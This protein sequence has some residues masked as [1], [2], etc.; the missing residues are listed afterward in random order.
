MRKITYTI[1]VLALFGSLRIYAQCDTCVIPLEEYINYALSYNPAI[2]KATNEL[3]LKT[4]AIKSAKS[5]LYPVISTDISGGF[6]NEYRSNLNYKTCMAVL[7]ADQAL[8]QNG[9]INADIEQASFLARSEGFTL[10]ARKMDIISS[11]KIAYLNCLLQRQLFNIAVDNV[12]K[13]NL[14]LEYAQERYNAGA[15]RKSEVLKAESDLY[16]AQFDKD[17][18]LNSIAE[19]QNELAMLTGL[20]PD[21]F[22]KLEDP[23]RFNRPDEFE[24]Q[25]DSLLT[26]AFRNYPE[27]QI[28]KNNQLA[29]RARVRLVQAEL[30]PRIGLNAGYNWSYNPVF[31]EQ[32]GWFTLVTFRWQLYNG[33]AHRTQIKSEI[34]R[35]TIIENAKSEVENWLL[36]EINNRI[37][38]IREALSQIR[39]TGHMIITTS[40]NLEI[41]RAQYTSGTGS[42]L[43]LADARIADLNSR[44]KNIKAVT[45]CQIAL[46]NLERLTENINQYKYQNE[47]S[48]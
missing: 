17:S 19:A 18:Y 33:N 44:Q 21:R 28:I 42:I 32:K 27:L 2:K 29:Q 47:K 23:L 45:A 41:A 4:L 30:F 6:S 11:V 43:E 1:I 39:L 7:S 31:Q 12:S 26:K 8:W 20:S 15:G 22:S 37:I 40:E 48:F 10:D 34:T 35:G 14:F 46:V 38:N 13:A 9:R 3:N 5:A 24:E 16:E 36:K 25:I